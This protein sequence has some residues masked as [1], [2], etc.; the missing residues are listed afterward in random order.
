MERPRRD[1]LTS[2]PM[3][4]ITSRRSFEPDDVGELLYQGVASTAFHSDF[5]NTLQGDVTY[6]L[7]PAYAG[8]GVYLGEYG[9]E[10]DDNSL[11]FPVDSGGRSDR[12]TRRSG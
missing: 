8:A 6:Q 1:S 11:V 2:S 7:G 4:R 10:A 5:D 9:V 3:R 12:R